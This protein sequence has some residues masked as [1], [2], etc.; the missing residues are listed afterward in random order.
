MS[1][2]GFSRNIELVNKTCSTFTS[3]RVFLLLSTAKNVTQ[4]NRTCITH[5]DAC[6]STPSRLNLLV[7]G[8][9]YKLK[10]SCNSTLI[11]RVYRCK[12]TFHPVE[13][14]VA[15]DHLWFIKSE[16]DQVTRNIYDHWFSF[17]LI[18][19]HRACKFMQVNR[20]N[21]ES[22]VSSDRFSRVSCKSTNRH[23]AGDG[24]NS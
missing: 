15:V 18:L 20:Q 19:D 1:V 16:N 17:T 10:S 23:N 3:Y 22:W 6:K 4:S 2:D 14:G 7:T 13:R 5:S 12:L 24:A 8:H 11:Q 21:Q 9:M